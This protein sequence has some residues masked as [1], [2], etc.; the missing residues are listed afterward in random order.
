V[1]PTGVGELDRVLSGGLVAGSVTLAF[2]EP[3]VGKSTL[4]LQALLSVASSGGTALLVSAEECTA[5][6]RSR[7]ERLGPVPPGVVVLATS[8]VEEIEQT[9]D[10]LH[11]DLVVVDS[12]QTVGDSAMPGPAGSLVQVRAC[13]E[14]L[15]RVARDSA[16]PVVLV[17]HVTKDGSLA[18]PRTLEHLVDTVVVVEGDR[19]H[20]LRMLRTVKHRFGPTGEVGLLE[21]GEAG[22]VEV[23]D[24]G[25]LL[26]GDRRPEVSGSTVTPLVQGRRPLLVEVQALVCDRGAAGARR[27]VQGLDPQRLS[28]LLAVLECRAG[29]DLAGREVFVSATGGVRATE[30]STDLALALAVASSATGRPLPPDLVS[31]GEVGLAGEVRQVSAPERRL[32]EAARLGFTR[33]LVPAATPQGRWPLEL[34]RVRSLLEGLAAVEGP[35][36]RVRPAEPAHFA[37]V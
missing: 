28:M 7:A 32:N 18:G 1:R 16:V 21:M 3:G 22:F 17:G 14:R 31:F 2:G 34:I 6:V 35:A 4:L 15:A 11:P 8:A 12:I 9:V 36:G 26:L 20:A 30:P 33:A 13:A 19:H 23:A 10:G 25:P 37:D 27:N 24:P 29:L 5:Q